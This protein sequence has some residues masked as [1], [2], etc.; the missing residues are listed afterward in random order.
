MLFHLLISPMIM[1]NNKGLSLD[2]ILTKEFLSLKIK[3]LQQSI[4][5]FFI[6]HIFPYQFISFMRKR[7]KSYSLLYLREHLIQCFMHR[8]LN[9]LY[10]LNNLKKKKQEP[11]FKVVDCQGR[12]NA[13]SQM[14]TLHFGRAEF[15]MFPKIMGREKGGN[16]MSLI[17]KRKE[18][19]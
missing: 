10:R 3:Y 8:K 14:S 19:I 15:K 9:K 5:Y 11:K 16:S 1:E 18:S 2:L 13:Q 6:V 7:P 4:F 17:F 12:H